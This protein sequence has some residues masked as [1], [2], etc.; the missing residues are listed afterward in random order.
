MGGGS[1]GDAC[2]VCVCVC[3]CVCVGGV[4]AGAGGLRM[5]MQYCV[6]PFASHMRKIHCI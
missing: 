6:R 2:G 3:V 1:C 5:I 4:G